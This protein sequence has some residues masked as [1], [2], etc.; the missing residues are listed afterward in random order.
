[1]MIAADHRRFS[2][3]LLISKCSVHLITAIGWES[4]SNIKRHNQT[5]LNKLSSSVALKQKNDDTRCLD[6]Q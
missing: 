3:F 1:M 6:I 5:H 2:A 4:S